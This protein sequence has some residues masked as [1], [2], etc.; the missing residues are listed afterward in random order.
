MFEPAPIDTGG[1]SP[2]D[3]GLLPSGGGDTSSGPVLS[4]TTVGT[5]PIGTAAAI[6]G[7]AVT[8]TVS[9][10][11]LT[12]LFTSRLVLFLL[13][14]ICVIAGL[15]MLKPGPVTTIVTA[16]IKAAKAGIKTAAEAGAATA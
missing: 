1:V 4:T 8:S 12:Y 2:S 10:S 14:I 13:G 3:S 16:P 7:K 15:Y 6:V 5:N 9:T 11:I